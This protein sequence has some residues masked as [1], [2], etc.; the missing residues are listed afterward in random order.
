MTMTDVQSWI[1]IVE[2]GVLALCALV[3][4]LAGM[5]RPGP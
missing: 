3:A 2:V 4:M 5:R 1:L